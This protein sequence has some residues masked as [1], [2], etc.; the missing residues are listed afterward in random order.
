MSGGPSPSVQSFSW[1]SRSS[2]GAVLGAQLL[3]QVA[4]GRDGVDRGDPRAFAGGGEG[5][6]QA[7]RP[8]AEHDDLLAGPEV[9]PGQGVHG[10]RRGL[11]EGGAVGVQV[12]DAEH[13]RRGDLEPL[14]Q[15]AVEVHADQAESR[16]HVRPSGPAGIAGAA[17]QQRP[18]GDPVALAYRCGVARR[19]GV[20]RRC[21]VARCGGAARIFD[22]RGHF[23]A[24]NAGI[25]V[26]GAG[27]RGH[28]TGKQMEVRTAD[29]HRLRPDDNVSGTGGS[30]TRNVLDHHLTG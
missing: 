2:G 14:L 6:G 25:E 16:A 9:R 18:D 22:D 8:G 26:A 12:T 24:L 7:D 5:G 27:K 29:T 20:A 11:D 15:A 17:G 28:V 21:G 23:V 4:A 3:G 1:V 13:G 19:G 10:H 30:R